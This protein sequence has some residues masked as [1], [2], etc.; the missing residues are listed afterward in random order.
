MSV[1]CK[2][3]KSVGEKVSRLSEVTTRKKSEKVSKDTFREIFAQRD[4]IHQYTPAITLSFMHSH[5]RPNA[6]RTISQ[7]TVKICYNADD[8]FKLKLFAGVLIDD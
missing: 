7:P 8:C 3:W 1:D 5:H 2:C 4:S 6:S